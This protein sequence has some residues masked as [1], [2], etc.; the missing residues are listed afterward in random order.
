MKIFIS[1]SGEK[2][3]LV[4][5]ALREWLP[6]VINDLEPF[7]SDEDIHSGTRWQAEIAGELEATNFGI[8]CVTQENQ[9]SPWL[10]FEAGALAKA[11]DASRVVPL[12]VDLKLSDIVLPLGQFQAQRATQEG[13]RK[14][15]FSLNATCDHPLDEDRLK[16]AASKWWS[17]LEEQLAVIAQQTAPAEVESPP[18]ETVDQ[19]L[20][21]DRELLEEMLDTVRSLA[22][23]VDANRRRPPRSR[24]PRD[25]V[26]EEIRAI[27]D[28]AGGDAEV[29]TDTGEPDLILVRPER[30]MPDEIK[31]R[32]WD[33]GSSHDITVGIVLSP[34][35]RAARKQADGEGGAT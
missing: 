5:L 27:L 13:I 9:D 31:R 35:E 19:E 12:A 14:V 28:A 20:R 33:T 4:A 17:D 18:D 23:D 2:S 16:K 1:W 6:W 34:E 25:R 7:V 22:R 30:T 32:L 29:E 10:N 8:I 11:V 26:V 15:L 3:R 21:T 24:P